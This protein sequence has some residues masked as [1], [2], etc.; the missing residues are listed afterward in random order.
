[1]NKAD[2]HRCCFINAIALLIL[3]IIIYLIMHGTNNLILVK[4]INLYCR[5]IPI[6]SGI[7][8]NNSFINN[9]LVDILWYTS[10]LLWISGFEK[11][12]LF[13]TIFSCIFGVC[14]ELFQFIFP[15]VGTFDIIDMLIYVF[16]TMIYIGIAKIK[17]VK[18]KK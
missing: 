7:N 14:L 16:I 1:M 9:Y 12:Q 15:S 8:I 4:K 3:A 11:N 2:K 18:Q 6:F 13:F 10:L 5:I 17:N